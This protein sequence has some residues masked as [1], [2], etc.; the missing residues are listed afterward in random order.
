[1]TC[2]TLQVGPNADVKK[3]QDEQ[4]DIATVTFGAKDAKEKHKVSI[5]SL[6]TPF[7]VY[8]AQLVCHCIL[9]NSVASSLVLFLQITACYRK[10]LALIWALIWL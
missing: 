8:S 9:S 3:W 7:S 1:M 6:S 10:L 4:I 5:T 2:T